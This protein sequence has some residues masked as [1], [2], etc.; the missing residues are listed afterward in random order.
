MKRGYK[1]SSQN[2]VVF[3]VLVVLSL[4]YI[5]VYIYIYVFI[6]VTLICNSQNNAC[7]RC[8]GSLK[9]V[10]FLWSAFTNNPLPKQPP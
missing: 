9:H 2:L 1:K 3:V 8:D 4:I 7:L 5:Y 6:I 10:T